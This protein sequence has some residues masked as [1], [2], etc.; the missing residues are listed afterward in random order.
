MEYMILVAIIVVAIFAGFILSWS[1]TSDKLLEELADLE[2]LRDKMRVEG[3]FFT[4]VL[5][6]QREIDEIKKELGI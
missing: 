6:I 1:R 5:D 3:Y 4:D 2:T